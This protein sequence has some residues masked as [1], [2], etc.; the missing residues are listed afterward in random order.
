MK[1]HHWLGMV[2]VTG[3]VFG[4]VITGAGVWMCHTGVVWRE[5]AKLI[6]PAAQR[7]VAEFDSLMI[8]GGGVGIIMVGL[9]VVMGAAVFGG[10]ELICVLDE[11]HRTPIRDSDM[12]DT[13]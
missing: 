2:T 10:G 8:G 12:E 4:A 7:A 13:T 5:A 6:E 11:L 1:R 3:V 9:G